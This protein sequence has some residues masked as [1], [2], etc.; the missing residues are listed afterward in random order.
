MALS[1]STHRVYGGI[2]SVGVV[3][4]VDAATVESLEQAIAAAF[5]GDQV[6]GV[7]VDLAGV[8]FLDSTGISA[9]LKGRRLA[10]DAG[11]GYR[12]D[13]ARGAV[14][15]ILEVAGVWQHLSGQPA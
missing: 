4:E 3:G 6:P 1:V 7:I 13:G 10:Q 5:M 15:Q 12:V 2:I 14:L 11:K 9:L 8:T